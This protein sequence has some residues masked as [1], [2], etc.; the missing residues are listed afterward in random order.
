MWEGPFYRE[1]PTA[2]AKVP[3]LGPQG[4]RPELLLL[5]LGPHASGWSSNSDW[6]K[7]VEIATLRNIDYRAQST[8]T[9][10]RVSIKQQFRQQL[11]SGIV[12]IIIGVMLGSSIIKG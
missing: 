4:L 5:E 8:S 3:K 9:P 1:P 12:G 7:K 10:R 2:I 11:G 6:I